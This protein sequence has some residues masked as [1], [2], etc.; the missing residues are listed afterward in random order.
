MFSKVVD[1]GLATLL[2]RIPP[3]EFLFLK[4]KLGRWLLDFAVTVKD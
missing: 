4:K 1:L 2:K 3:R